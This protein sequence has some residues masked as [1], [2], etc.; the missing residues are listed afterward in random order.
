MGTLRLAW[1]AAVDAPDLVEDGAVPV[2]VEVEGVGSEELRGFVGVSD[3]DVR[4]LR[5]CYLAQ[6]GVEMEDLGRKREGA[7]FGQLALWRLRAPEH[8]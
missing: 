8:A 2:G 7:G 5:L 3:D 6:L 1:L 4:L